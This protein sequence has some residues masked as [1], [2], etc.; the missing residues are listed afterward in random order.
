MPK[1]IIAADCETDPFLH[2]R[3]PEPFVWGAFDGKDF[4][5]FD[6]TAE[7]ADWAKD[8]DAFIYAH[9]GGKFDFMFLLPFVGEC[10]A[11]I[12]NGR[13][14]EMKF[15]KATL[16]DSY[17]IIPIPL[18]DFR[19]TE[20]EYWKL[21]SKVRASYWQEIV[22][23]LEDDCRDLFDIVGAFR[24]TAG[25]GLTIA[26]NALNF[27]KGL[28]INVGKSTKKYDDKFRPFYYGGRVQCFKPGAI[29]SVSAFD[30][31]SAYPFAMT[32]NHATGTDYFTDDSLEEYSD[33]QIG[34]LFIQIRCYS[35]GAFPVRE[36]GGLTFPERFGE[37]FVTGWEYNVAKKHGLIANENIIRVV[38]FMETVN[39]SPYVNHWFSHKDLADKRGDLAQRTVGKIMLNSLYGKLAQNP[40]HYRDYKIVPGGTPI[41]DLNGWILGAE[42]GEMEIHE[43]PVLWNLQLKY[44]E[45]WITKPVFYNVATAASITGFTR[46]HLLDAIHTVGYSSVVYCDTDCIFVTQNADVIKLD[47]S[48]ALGSWDWEGYADVAYMGGPKLYAMRYVNGPKKGKEKIATKG[49]RLSYDEIVRVVSGE[50]IVW[51]NAAPTFSIGQPP[52]FVVRKIRATALTST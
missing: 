1:K 17:S 21:E 9:N 11:K 20:I 32:H 5:T 31:K 30:I 49:A 46:A 27:A 43:R 50:T 33:E 25:K 48:G 2:G 4:L 37:F 14:A 29:Q 28:G 7:F 6:T 22:D 47:Q 38:E 41:D 23:Y 40:V 42:F 19:K 51:K 45:D 10:R 44:G 34:P 15:G 52:K 35:K 16:R 3:I 12:I 18:K 36:G 8:Q 13:I 24:E 39:F 26:G